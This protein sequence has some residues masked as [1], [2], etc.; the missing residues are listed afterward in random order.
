MYLVSCWTEVIWYFKG[1]LHGGW[2][3]S[4]LSLSANHVHLDMKS[5]NFLLPLLQTP[6]GQ[7]KVLLQLLS[8]VAGMLQLKLKVK[9]KNVKTILTSLLLPRCSLSLSAWSC[10]VASWRKVSTRIFR[11]S[12][13]A[14]S[15]V[16]SSCNKNFFRII[17]TL[18]FE[19]SVTVTQM[20]QKAPLL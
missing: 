3:V 13:S 8:A 11:S 16:C 18:R 15:M 19:T 6:H 10:L 17:N 4:P 2:F 14:I 1:I 12:R 7:G 5:S 20:L 9:M